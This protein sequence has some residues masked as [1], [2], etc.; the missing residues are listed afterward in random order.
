MKTKTY[1]H[2]NL[3]SYFPARASVDSSG[4]VTYHDSPRYSRATESQLRDWA[5]SRIGSVRN[6]AVTE[7]AERDLEAWRSR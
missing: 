2:T 4:F 6:A 1:H 3:G 5:D 7:M